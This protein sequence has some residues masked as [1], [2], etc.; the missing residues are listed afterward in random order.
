MARIVGFTRSERRV[1]RGFDLFDCGSARVGELGYSAIF[2]GSPVAMGAFVSSLPRN[3]RA[4]VSP[5]RLGAM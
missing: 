2:V 1:K 4:R 5:D 3:L